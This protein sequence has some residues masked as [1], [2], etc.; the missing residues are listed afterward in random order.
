MVL[1]WIIIDKTLLINT[2]SLGELFLLVKG[3]YQLSFWSSHPARWF[4]LSTIQTELT[5]TSEISFTKE[6]SII[7]Y[8]SKERMPSNI[9]GFSLSGRPHFN[10]PRFSIQ[11]LPLLAKNDLLEKWPVSAR[12]KPCVPS[13]NSGIPTSGAGFSLYKRSKYL[14]AASAPGVSR[15]CPG[16]YS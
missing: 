2:R 11:K 15:S 9:V 1:Q 12:L 16:A 6:R 4:L 14:Q 7:Y 10:T 13:L 5:C 8:G 3:Y